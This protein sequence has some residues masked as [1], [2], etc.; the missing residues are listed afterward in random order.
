VAARVA[1]RPA[2]TVVSATPPP[3]AVAVGV[4]AGAERA[5]QRHRS[6]AQAGGAG[7]R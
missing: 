6:A 1:S 4:A 2:F 7:G 5:V 3:V